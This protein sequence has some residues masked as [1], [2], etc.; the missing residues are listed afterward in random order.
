M[1]K[2]QEKINKTIVSIWSKWLSVSN[3]IFKELEATLVDLSLLVDAG[4]LTTK[5]IADRRSIPRVLPY[6]LDRARNPNYGQAP[7]PDVA[8]T[9]PFC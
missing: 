4:N 5:K 3:L 1:E 6:V 8:C 2:K 7:Y 9:D